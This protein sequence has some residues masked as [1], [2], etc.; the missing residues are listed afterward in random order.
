MNEKDK[1]LGSNLSASFYLCAD[2]AMQNGLSEVEAAGM[3]KLGII[4]VCNGLN[5]HTL[6]FANGLTKDQ[7]R[8]AYATLPRLQHPGAKMLTSLAA[9][10]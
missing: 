8:Q 4:A 5:G 6:M 3:L 2:F 10:F 9:L 1:Q 7:A